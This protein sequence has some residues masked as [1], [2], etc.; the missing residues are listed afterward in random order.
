MSSIGRSPR[1]L[2]FFL[3]ETSRSS[4]MCWCD[5]A[6]QHSKSTLQVGNVQPTAFS[7]S[8]PC[9]CSSSRHACLSPCKQSPHIVTRASRYRMMC[10]KRCLHIEET[11]KRHRMQAWAP[12]HDSQT[13]KYRYNKALCEARSA[14]RDNHCLMVL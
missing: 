6:M 13:K 14:L 3:Q 5:S 1:L 12:G 7:Y 4:K 8:F 2:I 9:A 10:V 11:R